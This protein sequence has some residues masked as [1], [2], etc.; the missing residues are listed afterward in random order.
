MD[1]TLL[2]RLLWAAIM[3]T[4]CGDNTPAPIVAECG[5]APVY[6]VGNVSVQTGTA[7]MTLFHYQ[8]LVTFGDDVANW[9]SCVEGV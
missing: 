4:G 6:P 3:L 8:E 9:A 1:N 5:P 2:R 7:E